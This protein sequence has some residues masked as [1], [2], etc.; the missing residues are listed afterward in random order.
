MDNNQKQQNIK[1]FLMQNGYSEELS[2][3]LISDF[4]KMSIDDV[5]SFYGMYIADTILDVY[6]FEKILC[7][8]MQD[9]SCPNSVRKCIF[10]DKFNGFCKLHGEYANAVSDYNCFSKFLAMVGDENIEA[11]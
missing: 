8:G 2:V 5:M 4:S 9:Y 7:N 11:E 6:S 10:H 1:D 3:E